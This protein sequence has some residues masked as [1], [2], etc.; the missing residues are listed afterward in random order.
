MNG[1]KRAAALLGLGLLLPCLLLVFAFGLPGQYGETY[2]AA[3][4]DKAAA[5]DA[6]ESPKIV[7]IGGSGAAFNVDCEL[8]SQALPGYRAV[9][10]GLYAGL[11]VPVMLELALPGLRAGDAVV[12]LP[13]MSPQTLSDF[14]DPLSFWQAA[15]AAPGL[16]LRLAPDRWEGLLAALPR[17]AG[18]K[19]AYFLAGDRPQGSGIYARS[20]FTLLGD[21]SR[22]QRPANRMPGGW[23]ENMP[24]AMDSGLLSEDFL[25][26]LS[27]FCAACR[28]RG[29]GVYFRLCPM[30]GA[31]LNDGE[32]EKAPALDAAL[33]SLLPCPLLG[34]AA[35]A[36]MDPAWF[37]DTNFH[38]NGPGAEAFTARLA[39]ELADA[40]NI[41]DAV[42]L[43]LP[44]MPPL[45]FAA[46]ASGDNSDEGC[47]TYALRQGGYGVTGLTQ[48]GMR[49]ETL[50]LP[51]AHQGQPVI[52]LENGAFRASAA[53]K[54]VKIQSSLGLIA[55]G[56]F[57]GCQSLARIELFQPD[58][59]ALS[60]GPGLL[61]DTKAE[62]FVP[63][64]SFGNYC[65]HYFWAAH[66]HRLRPLTE[67]ETETAAPT[68]APAVTPKPRPAAL[69]K[70]I[71]R[72]NGGFLRAGAGDSLN[73]ALAPFRDKSASVF[74]TY[75]PRNSAS[76]T[77]DSTPENRRAL[78]QYLR[79]T[80][81]FPVISEIEESLLPGRYFW[82]IDTHLST[83][84]AEI[85]TRRAIEDLR[86]AME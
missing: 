49:Q 11:G 46:D 81:A 36:V 4:P 35:E 22:E 24:L 48:A 79:E 75:T 6:V 85:R 14:F 70:I 68:P 13:E 18:E 53:L 47:F 54:T 56:A 76:L 86:R 61:A 38:L 63:E 58:P 3:L 2:L 82:L 78:D 43:P 57:A 31:A 15:E 66:A 30:N 60:V 69:Q 72:G 21:V 42:S 25:S 73:A 8:L 20:S 9:N 37:Y 44:A 83:Q 19:A 80:L 7:V 28:G 27:A 52:A 45:A 23:D 65:T 12:F 1:K 74:F 55:D 5:L 39:G 50:T 71:Y 34:S 84:G 17:F 51:A 32:I 10:F 16:A 26:R 64:A 40:L 29:V 33:Q 77:K 67:A 41:R 62:M 59:G